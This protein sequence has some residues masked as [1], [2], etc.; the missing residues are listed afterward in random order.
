MPRPA[1]GGPESAPAGRVRALV[2]DDDPIVA[3]S[4]GEF[5]A[6]EGYRVTVVTDPAQS[7]AAARG[8]AAEPAAGIMIVDM[9]LPGVPGGGLEVIRRLREEHP[10]LVPVV[11]TGYGT[12]ESAVEAVRLGAADYLTKPVV[13]S[14]LRLALERAA[15][16]HVLLEENRALQTRLDR[17][18][19]LEAIVGHDPRMQRIYEL[20]EAVAPTRTTVLMTGESG[21]GKSLIAQAIHQRS[22]RRNAAFV[23]LACGSIPETLLESELFGHTR[24]AF[25]GAHSDK[26]GRFLLA[27]GGT[28]LLDEINS[29]S[30]GMQLKLLRVLQERRFEPVGTGKTVEVDVRVILASNQPL[31]DL[32]AR[33]LFRQ[34]L[35]YRINVVKIEV[36]PL[37]ERASD[38]PM[39]AR[40]F[41][42]RHSAAV[43]KRISGIDP[44]AMA[45]LERYHYPGNVRELGNLIE[46]ACVLA[47]RPTI[48]T[49]DLPAE[50]V[51]RG[52]A[53]PGHEP[54][55]R[56][57]A[58]A[59]AA[60]QAEP[61]APDQVRPLDEAMR[62]PERRIIL[63]ALRACAWNR[64]RAAERLGI[65]RATLYKK[66]AALGIDPAVEAA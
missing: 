47:K 48:T 28:L 41:L 13:E 6:T 34:D 14:D 21:V 62:E 15:R 2:I 20:V 3:Q 40:H 57:Q 22:P 56:H 65:N 5:L 27:D 42:D 54:A 37:R 50:I 4:L 38:V 39:L 63:G 10:C 11:L 46:R 19:G 16:Q 29:A 58:A 36:P 12:I 25:T 35:Y 51:G 55:G 30:P 31:E 61:A 43:G 9:A 23:E 7:P 18:F 60:F 8:T 1:G 44:A 17:A 66:M 59:A 32:V 53:G 64:A 52:Q 26:P 45:A 33:G 24:G 49:D